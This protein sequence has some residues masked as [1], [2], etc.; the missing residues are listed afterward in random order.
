MVATCID[1]NPVAA[2]VAFRK[3]RIL[4]IPQARRW[5]NA[6]AGMSFLSLRR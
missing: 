6:F 2:G 4:A 3:L 1:S 5:H